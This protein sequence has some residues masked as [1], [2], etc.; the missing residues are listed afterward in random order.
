MNK[1]LAAF[2]LILFCKAALAGPADYIYLPAVQYGEREIDFKY[3]NASPQPGNPT[4]GAS[5][6]FG[7]GV[8]ENW[9]TEIYLKA[10]QGG[11]ADATISEWEN[12]FQLTDIGEY[13]VDIGY[14]IE[15]EAPLSHNTPWELTTG[16]LFQAE[17]GSMQLNANLLFVRNYGARDENSAPYVTNLNYQW[18]AKYLWR[19][20]LD[21]GLQGFGEVGKWNQ[22]DPADQ[23]NHRIGPAVMGKLLLG[24]RNV[25]S[26]NAAWLFGSSV[27]A[28]AHT[29]RMQVEYEF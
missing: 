20:V 17:S 7:Y 28:P 3:G 23:Q 5:L 2:S 21:F 18:Q 29:F 6:G 1:W 14:I 26:Y 4:Q 10:E 24:G 25:I 22:W 8:T 19:S 13:P 12:K 15:V 27:A 16:P 9:F 11:N